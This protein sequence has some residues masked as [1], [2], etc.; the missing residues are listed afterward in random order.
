MPVNRL[1]IKEAGHSND[2]DDDDD[3]GEDVSLFTEDELKVTFQDVNCRNFLYKVSKFTFITLE[4]DDVSLLSKI[5]S[6]GIKF[7]IIFAVFAFIVSTH[8]ALRY[9]PDTCDQP[10]CDDDP[11][12]CP[13]YAVCEPVTL[14]VFDT[15]EEA[16]TIIFT[17]EYGLRVVTLWAVTPRVAGIYAGDLDIPQPTYSLLY[18]YVKYATQFKNIVD[19]LTI[20][21]FYLTLVIGNSSSSFI[22]VL[23]LLRIIRILRLLRLLTFMKNV[24]VAADIIAATLSGGWLILSVFAFFIALTVIVFGCCMYM[25]EQ[26]QFTVT[27]QYPAGVYL[28]PTEDQMDLQPTPFDSVLTAMYW[29]IGTLTGNADMTA[30]TVQGRALTNVLDIVG[31]FSLSFPIGIIASELDRAYR[32]YYHELVQKEVNEH[33]T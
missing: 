1:A 13:G 15:I 8:P 3:D 9:T 31:V 33:V 27:S 11:T 26:G 17:I 19:V 2:H 20:I 12:L 24:D 4:L 23:R 14:P 16:V 7:V 30:T 22:R 10:A 28:R 32:T 6:V 29:A 21:P 25:C 5:C 18:T